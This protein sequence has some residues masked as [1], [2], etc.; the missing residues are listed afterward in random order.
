M[1]QMTLYKKT[2]PNASTLFKQD[3][4]SITLALLGE[5]KHNRL[6]LIFLY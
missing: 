2:V 5:M 3:Y 4:L 6:R 1:S